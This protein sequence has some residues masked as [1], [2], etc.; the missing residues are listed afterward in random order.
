MTT[1]DTA[2]E[3]TTPEDITA[4][5]VASFDAAPDAR[6]RELMQALV[7]H[8]HAFAAE[9]RLTEEEWRAAIATL[10]ATGHITDEQRQEFI[11]WSDALGVSMLVDA[12]ANLRP[13]GAT[14]STVLGPF[15]VPG[16][17]LREYGESIAAEPAGTPT[18]V[19]GHVRDLDGAPIAGAELDVWQNGDDRLYAVQKPEGPAEHLRGRFR[20]R[21]DGSY[22]FLAVRPVPYPIP[23]DGPVGRMLAATGR[24]PWRPAHIHMIVRA[25]GYETVT[26]HVF[27]AA[28]EY[29]DSDA[30]FAVKPSL[31]RE[32]A[33]RAADDPD[34]PDGVEGEWASLQCDFVLARGD[35]AREP[36]DP[37]RT[38]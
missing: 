1:P 26:T 32:I 20:T 8:V 36:T 11:L 38:A 25:D 35:A 22:A 17:P 34:R 14:E 6:L 9:V 3:R 10:T 37:G 29:L 30:V 28:S 4:A 18:W 33:P 2:A 15:Y 21:D 31:M 7:R 13:P 12:L 5:V 27:D 23:D 16:S 24:H 19:H